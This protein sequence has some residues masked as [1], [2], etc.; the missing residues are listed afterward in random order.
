ME[1]VLKKRLDITNRLVAR[2]KSAFVLTDREKELLAYAKEGLAPKEIGERMGILSRTVQSM[3]R[4][5]KEKEIL[6]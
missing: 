2:H 1:R 6:Q 5:A 4:K 3:L